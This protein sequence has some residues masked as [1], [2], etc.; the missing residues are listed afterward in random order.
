MALQAFAV[1][2]GIHFFRKVL[3]HDLRFSYNKFD[4][5]DANKANCLCNINIYA[6]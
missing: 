5:A 3:Y 1:C 6:V 4:H 2:R